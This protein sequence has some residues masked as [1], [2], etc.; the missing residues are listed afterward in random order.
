MSSMALHQDTAA[1]TQFSCV[2]AILSLQPWGLYVTLNSF[3]FLQTL[4]NS[5]QFCSMQINL[6]IITDRNRQN[7]AMRQGRSYPCYPGAMYKRAWQMKLEKWGGSVPSQSPLHDCAQWFRNSKLNHLLSVKHSVWMGKYNKCIWGKKQ[8]KI[9]RGTLKNNYLNEVS[10]QVKDEN[11]V[12]S[13]YP[14]TKE[15]QTRERYVSSC[16]LWPS[17][18][19]T[20]WRG[21]TRYSGGAKQ[22]SRRCLETIPQVS[23]FLSWDLLIHKLSPS[24]FCLHWYHMNT[25]GLFYYF[26]SNQASVS[27]FFE[28]S[29]KLS[30]SQ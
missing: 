7:L 15:K 27:T 1:E 17:V 14:Q 25:P 3:F 11:G 28:A 10:I 5:S 6:S 26:F 29:H 20:V 13:D 19:R 30:A 2:W 21:I 24:Q 8:L 12:K 4:R 22:S 16:P 9:S 23:T 18:H